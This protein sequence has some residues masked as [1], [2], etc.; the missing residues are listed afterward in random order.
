MNAKKAFV[1]ARLLIPEYQVL[2]V[3]TTTEPYYYVIAV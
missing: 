1:S 3:Q 2:A